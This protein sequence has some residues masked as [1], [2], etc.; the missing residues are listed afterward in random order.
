MTVKRVRLIKDYG[1]DDFK[2]G[3]VF[4]VLAENHDVYTIEYEHGWQ[5]SSGKKGWNIMKGDFKVVHDDPCGNCKNSCRSS[6]KCPFYQE[7]K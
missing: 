2:K 7:E 6:E 3:A 1:N 5:H 4:N